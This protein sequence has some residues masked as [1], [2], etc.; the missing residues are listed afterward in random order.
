MRRAFRRALA[1]VL[2]VWLAAMACNLTYVSPAESAARTAT[3]EMEAYW[4]QETQTWRDACGP[5]QV[6]ANVNGAS[7]YAGP[8]FEYGLVGQLSSGQFAFIT[9]QDAAGEWWYIEFAA[10]PGGH[11]WTLAANISTHCLQEGIAII[12]TPTLPA[13]ACQPIV[14]ANQ[15][16]NVRVGPSTLYAI[17]GTL[18]AG[19]TATIAGKNA[20]S[21][22]WYID[23]A[24]G[25]G[26]HG[27]IAANTVT[28]SCVP[29]TVVVIT[30]PPLPATD[31][32]SP[33]AQPDLIVSEFTISPETPTT[34]VPAHVRIGVF[35][36]GGAST[37]GSYVVHWYGLS[38]YSEPSC[39]W[40]VNAT[41]PQGS[42][43][44]ECDFAF[45]EW[46]PHDRTSLVVVDADNDVAESNENNNEGTISGFGVDSPLT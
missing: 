29:A 36:Q 1:A 8:G 15:N 22:W 17:I 41:K 35:N 30:P 46:Y 27:W 34:G 24:A 3:A 28:A 11:G 21:T 9:G 20:D 38:S 18:L 4:L 32:P 39:S 10:G 40:T 5:P 19:E 12:T 13:T 16:A 42:R 6:I 14:T 25:P 26:G 7:V 23:F 37:G 2:A 31:T 45:P 43:V 33:N 44:L